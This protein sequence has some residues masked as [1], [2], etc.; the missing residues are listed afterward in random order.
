MV[1][2]SFIGKG[3]A[4]AV[5]SI[6][7]L[8]VFFGSWYTVDEGERGVKLRTGSVVDE[9]EPGLRFKLPLAEN[10]VTY[11]VRTNKVTWGA[12]SAIVAY[13]KDVQ[14][15]TGTVSVNYRLDSAK[16]SDIYRKY[17]TQIEATMLYPR[18]QKSL[19]EVVGT[20]S[21]ADLVGQRNAIGKEFT[22]SL[23]AD[24]PAEI[25][26]EGVQIE[27]LDFE[28]GYEQA[29]EQVAKMEASSREKDKE[30]DKMKKE[31]EI[32][33]VNAA[34]EADAVK[35]AADAEA[36]AIKVKTSAEAEGIREKARALAE[37]T[38]L[39][40]Y[41]ASL[42]WD[43]KLPTTMVPGGTIPFIDVNKINR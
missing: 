37:N 8:T 6:F 17:G 10:V 41:Q 27:N 23:V 42:T 21:A 28:D 26:I 14:K 3:I 38:N 43:G 39:V 15:V 30:L 13:S 35:L 34:A 12:D 7:G 40:H 22:A 9:V 25:I 24:L 29:A 36:H 4:V 1:N 16:V 32:T 5:A 19:K 11:S 33:V 2:K 31:A 20:R 18:V